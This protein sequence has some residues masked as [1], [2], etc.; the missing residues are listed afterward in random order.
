MLNCS[1]SI[2]VTAVLLHEYKIYYTNLKL[3]YANF[4]EDTYYGLIISISISQHSFEAKKT[5][6]TDF[7]QFVPFQA[8]GCSNTKL[9][10]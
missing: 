1:D 7:V 3:N 9:N 5:V 10:T 2:K 4:F 8:N 6:Q